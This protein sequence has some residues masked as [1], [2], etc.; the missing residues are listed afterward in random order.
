MLK[1]RN[2]ITQRLYEEANITCDR[3]SIIVSGGPRYRLQES[4]TVES[5][6][7]AVA[8]NAVAPDKPD[9]T[10]KID[11]LIAPATGEANLPIDF[12]EHTC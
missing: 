2:K 1:F 3:T 11:S 5:G 12:N 8:I 6:H 7:H 9:G 4:V 10:P